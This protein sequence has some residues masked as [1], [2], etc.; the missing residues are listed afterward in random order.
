MGSNVSLKIALFEKK[1]F[2][3]IWIKNAKNN[4]RL[5]GFELHLP[6]QII[7]MSVNQTKVPFY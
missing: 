2:F 1:L 6:F 3:S 7:Q 5:G 4:F